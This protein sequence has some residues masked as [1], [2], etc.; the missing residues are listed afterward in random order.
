MENSRKVHFLVCYILTGVAPCSGLKGLISL[1]D[2]CQDLGEFILPLRWKPSL[3]QMNTII[4]MNKISAK[5]TQRMINA[6][7]D[8]ILF[9]GKKL[10][11]YQIWCI[12][13]NSMDLM[14]AS[15]KDF[16]NFFWQFNLSYLVGRPSQPCSGCQDNCQLHLFSCVIILKLNLYTHL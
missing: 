16:I 9:A 3:Q 12:S 8:A 14:S 1:K 4:P 13:N 2:M 6:V 15:L 10:A 7:V 11:A 5:I